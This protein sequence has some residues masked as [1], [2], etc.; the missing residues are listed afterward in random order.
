MATVATM[1]GAQFDALPYDEGRRWDLV[2][3]EPIAVSS[4][5]PRHQEIVFRIL[6]ALRQYLGTNKGLAYSD[7]E[8]ALTDNDRLRPDVCVLLGT[9][10]AGLDLDQVPIAGAPDIA[11]E[12]ISPTERASDSHEKVRAYLR[13]GTRE[14]WQVYPKSS[15]VQIHRQEN[16]YRAERDDQITSGLLPGFQLAIQS[17]YAD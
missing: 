5:T 12:V 15:T 10:A 11:V 14:V 3:G 8:F 4:P 2:S 17:L 7:V 13:S 6:L 9:K 16:S 1:T